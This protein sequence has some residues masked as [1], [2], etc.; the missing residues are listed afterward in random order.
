MNTVEVSTVV[1]VPPEEV[2][3]FIVDFPRYSAYSKHLSEVTRDGDGGVGTDYRLRFTWWKLGYTARTRVTDVDPPNRIDWEVTKDLR[4]H[5][6]WEVEAAPEAAPPDA[7]AA[8]RVT[9]VVTYDPDSAEAGVLDLP[10][11]VSLDWVLDRVSDLVVREGERVVERIV[12]DLEGE[13]RDVEL[14]VEQY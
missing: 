10:M 6:R 5:G 7:D 1:H 13:R 12:A 2:Y 9:L 14:T 8:S 4:A 11:L 3:E